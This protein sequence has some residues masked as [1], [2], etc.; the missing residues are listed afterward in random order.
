MCLAVLAGAALL[1]SCGDQKSAYDYNKEG[2]AFY[3]NRDFDQA[4][5]CLKK[6]L[7]LEPDD[8]TFTQNYAMI[9][10][11]K[12]DQDAAIR[13]FESTLLEKNTGRAKQND[14]YAYRGIGMALLQKKDYNRAVAYF[15][16]AIE[17]DVKPEW[18]IDIK[19]YRAN[20]TELSGDIEKAKQLY[21]D[22]IKDDPENGA[23]YEALARIYYDAGDYENAMENYNN[24]LKYEDGGFT[25][26]IGLASCCLKTGREKEA[27]E[28]LFLASLLK[29]NTDMD[30]YYLGVVHY[31]QQ[32]Y[33][34]AKP[35]ME[36]ALANGIRDAYFYLAEMVLLDEDYEKAL[37]YF[38]EYTKTA[39][40]KS[41]TVCNDVAVC[42]IK[43]GDYETAA[44][45]VKEG[46]SFESS[47]VI[48]ELKKN[49]IVC[50]EGLG[51]L[52][53]AYDRLGEYIAAYPG[54]EAANK[55]YEYLKTR[56]KGV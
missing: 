4:A 34:S 27:E 51:N 45:W 49:E 56:I 21:T 2:M 31:Y 23:S 25:T 12:G 42:C 16:Q 53:E 44:E 1:T 46:L 3:E 33:D 20:A 55:E 18:N 41:A 6:A 17:I 54:D 26:Y 8:A 36:Y 5:D 32:K 38:N 52:R 28:A 19:Y 37:E 39:S 11:Q 9:M 10:M 47:A 29:I 15:D 24:A 35:E 22:I 13:L 40:I 48:K 43:K 14:K 30:K 7:E 50:L